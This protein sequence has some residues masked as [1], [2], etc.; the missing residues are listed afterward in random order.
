MLQ[1]DID[2][3]IHSCEKHLLPQNTSNCT[4]I[5]YPLKISGNNSD[6]T[7]HYKPLNKIHPFKNLAS[8]FHAFHNLCY[9]K[10]RGCLNHLEP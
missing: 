7:I 1:N 8:R 4:Q 6:F 9:I 10:P 5:A 3:N 2:I